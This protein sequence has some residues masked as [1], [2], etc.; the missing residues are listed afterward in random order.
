[1]SHGHKTKPAPLRQRH[2]VQKTSQ[3][4]PN[5]T[6]PLTTIQRL[7]GRNAAHLTPLSAEDVNNLHQTIGTQATIQL[8]RER[9]ANSKPTPVM[10]AIYQPFKIERT[11]STETQPSSETIQRVGGDE[12]ELDFFKKIQ[13]PSLRGRGGMT[14]HL[15]AGTTYDQLNAAIQK[16]NRTPE[17]N[18]AKLLKL[19]K[20]IAALCR[21][22]LAHN[23][24]SGDEPQAKRQKREDVL[25]VY[26]AG[27]GIT[28][29]EDKAGDIVYQITNYR[30]FLWTDVMDTYESRNAPKRSSPRDVSKLR[31][32]M[33]SAK[34]S[35]SS[36]AT[37]RNAS[38]WIAR[39]RLSTPSRRRARRCRY[40]LSP[41]A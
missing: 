8:L 33:M 39:K 18:L 35:S 15:I 6:T 7:S 34:N 24:Q 21:Q 31:R 41:P 32:S 11:P 37:C 10:K 22:W 17:E 13:F 3:S 30:S 2:V 20:R 14:M 19:E 40:R 5:T 12:P 27:L 1:M 4:S 29:K 26:R 23:P 25:G 9:A 28:R 38:S 16:Y 36:S